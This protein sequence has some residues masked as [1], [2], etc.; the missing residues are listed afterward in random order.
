MACRVGRACELE[1]ASCVARDIIAPKIAEGGHEVRVVN[2]PTPEDANRHIAEFKPDVVWWVGHGSQG[3]TSLERVK[4]WI[5]DKQC[6]HNYG[7][8][9]K[10]VLKGK[11]ANALSCHTAAC[12]GLRQ[13]EGGVRYWL[14]YKKPF[15][16]IWCYC[17]QTWG[18]ACGRYNPNPKVRDEVNR[19]V[20][21]CMHDANLFFCVGLAKGFTPEQAHGYSLMRFDKWIEHFEQFEPQTPEEA[22][23]V[24]MAVRVLKM[25]RPVQ[26][27]ES[28]GR[29]VEAETPPEEPPEPP[30]LPPIKP[31]TP[32]LRP[33]PLLVG[34]VGAGMMLPAL[35]RR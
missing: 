15:W 19:Q 26:V 12:L 8:K 23:I 28:G 3:A 17:P 14:G 24:A 35:V 27:L 10:E 18:C 6:P 34:A 31:P 7:D 11:I 13:T 33:L 2:S 20:M 9:N 32:T 21:I 29:E 4:I 22:S 25:D 5:S 1:Y 30:E 16:F